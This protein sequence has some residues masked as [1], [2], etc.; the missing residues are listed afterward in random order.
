MKLIEFKFKEVQT[1]KKTYTGENEVRFYLENEDEDKYFKRDEKYHYFIKCPCM[2]NKRDRYR[3]CRGYLERNICSPYINYNVTFIDNNERYY[4]YAG[5]L[6]P[7][8]LDFVS[9]K[10]FK[11][12]NTTPYGPIA[13][14]N[15]LEEAQKACDDLNAIRKEHVDMIDIDDVIMKYEQAKEDVKRYSQVIEDNT[16]E[17][18]ENNI[19]GRCY[20]ID[21]YENKHFY[22]KVTDVRFDKRSKHIDIICEHGYKCI[23]RETELDE[24]HSEY[25]WYVSSINEE[26]FYM[27]NNQNIYDFFKSNIIEV[28]EEEF[29]GRLK[30]E[31][32]ISNI[33]SF[34]YFSFKRYK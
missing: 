15:T 23:C 21:D 33:E 4:G 28:T 1:G 24:R 17:F 9:Q 3:V 5:E 8:S 13:I 34:P 2:N 25:K 29:F 6:V 11:D 14:F 7:R 30:K 20:I 12:N 19:L 31:I 10:Y 27:S 22:Y 16:E 18:V 26:G 32:K